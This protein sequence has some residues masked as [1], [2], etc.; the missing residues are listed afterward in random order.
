MEYLEI[1][2]I[3]SMVVMIG[4]LARLVGGYYTNQKDKHKVAI[5]RGVT[6]VVSAAVLTY[7]FGVA[8]YFVATKTW[9]L[10]LKVFVYFHA[11]LITFYVGFLVVA[12]ILKAFFDKSETN[13]TEDMNRAGRTV[14]T[15]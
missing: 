4:V 14:Y 12:R 11:F 9:S 5:K 1:W 3:S 7:L 10:D 2:M 15:W 6:N 8:A 13:S